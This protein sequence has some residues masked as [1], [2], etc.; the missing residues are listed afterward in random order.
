MIFI[1]KHREKII[2]NAQLLYKQ[3]K[4]NDPTAGYVKSALDYSALEKMCD[5]W[6]RFKQ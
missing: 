6:M 1:R 2:A 4:V 5:A 3:K